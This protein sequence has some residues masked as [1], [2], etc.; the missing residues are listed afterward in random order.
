MIPI[1]KIIFLVFLSLL[2]LGT[3][4]KALPPFAQQTAGNVTPLQ[5]NILT[6]ALHYL[7]QFWADQGKSL[8]RKT[9]AKYFTPNITLVINGKLVFTG[10]DQFDKHFKSVGK[11]IIGQIIFPL[12]E[13]IYADNTLVAYFDED[14]RDKKTG[15]HYPAQVIALFTLQ[16]NKIER[17]E[18]VANTAYFCRADANNIVYS[19]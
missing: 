2:S 6:G 14:I 11:N 8:S 18:E 3:W 17:W 1:K 16:H 4:S 15:Q 13:V 9:T 10:Y 7:N 19:K 12:H 5:E